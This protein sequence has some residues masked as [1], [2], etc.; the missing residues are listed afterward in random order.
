MLQSSHFGQ[1]AL[2]TAIPLAKEVDFIN[3]QKLDVTKDMVIFA[4][5]PCDAESNLTSVPLEI[6]G[7]VPEDIEAH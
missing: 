3:E 1:K 7:R 6:Y 4:P 5:A 2:L